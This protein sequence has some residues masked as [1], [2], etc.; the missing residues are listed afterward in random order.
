MLGFITF[1]DKISMWFGKAFAWLIVLMTLGVSYEVLVRYVLGRPTPWAFDISYMMYGSLFMMAGAYALSRNAHVRADFI[2]RLW[3]VRTQATIELILYILF[4]F[5]GVLALIFAGWKYARSSWR[6]MEV[7]QF[8]PANIPIFQFKTLIV[9]A[10]L[11][12]FIQGIAQVCRCIVAMRTGEWPQQ[13]EDV[14]E[15]EAVLLSERD[16]GAVADLIG[17]T[18]HVGL[19]GSEGQGR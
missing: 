4:F 8:S 7:S 11:L 18:K 12:L 9:A 17:D 16:R 14:E 2:Y 19:S 15:L 6:Y 1:I 13:V 5:P 10:G 3:P